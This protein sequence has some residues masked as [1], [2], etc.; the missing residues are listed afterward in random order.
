MDPQTENNY[1]VPYNSE[2]QITTNSAWSWMSQ[3][4]VVMLYQSLLILASCDHT[5]PAFSLKLDV[6][7]D[8]C[9]V[10]SVFINFSFL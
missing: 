9:D 7:D 3:M 1:V 8:R 10:I 2:K 4:T 5:E 6:T